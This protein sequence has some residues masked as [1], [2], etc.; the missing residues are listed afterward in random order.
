MRR[1]YKYTL[2]VRRAAAQAIRKHPYWMPRE[3]FDAVEAETGVRLSMGVLNSI[4]AEYGLQSTAESR[5]YRKAL[6]IDLYGRRGKYMTASDMSAHLMTA[7]G[8]SITPENIRTILTKA[9]ITIRHK[10]WHSEK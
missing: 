1:P 2:Q 7:Y 4:R 6:I 9:G 10:G 8:I 3:I 5:V